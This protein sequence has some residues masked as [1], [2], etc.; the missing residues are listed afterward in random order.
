[1][2]PV[3]KNAFVIKIKS[4]CLISFIHSDLVLLEFLNAESIEYYHE[5]YIH[6]FVLMLVLSF[7]AR[8]YR[9]VFLHPKFILLTT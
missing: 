4:F 3:V 2:V 6:S 9:E 1:M 5:V 7:P 8:I